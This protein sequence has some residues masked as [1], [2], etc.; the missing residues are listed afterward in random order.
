MKPNSHNKII[1]SSY[2][3]KNININ[4][5]LHFDDLYY[6]ITTSNNLYYLTPQKHPDF[7]LHDPDTIFHFLKL[8][9]YEF[10]K[11]L[12]IKIADK[13]N[14][15][16]GDFPKLYSL[17]NLIILIKELY[18]EYESINRLPKNW[19]EY[20]N[21]MRDMSSYN[22]WY[23]TED[24]SISNNTRNVSMYKGKNYCISEQEAEAFLAL[25]QLRQFYK[26]YIKEWKPNWYDSTYKSIIKIR[27]GHPI[28]RKS[29][30]TASSFVF[31]NKELA[32]FFIDN[33]KDLLKQA[34]LFL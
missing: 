9:K 5:V 14:M 15:F 21:Y 27:K 3:I 34:Q 25:M 22:F 10:C 20:C 18:K 32:Q 16:F 30:N 23:V 6:K 2:D 17:D 11:K 19:E 13:K 29:I 26:I 7:I 4:D 24:G 12:N 33:F 28:V 1:K 31:P 8:D